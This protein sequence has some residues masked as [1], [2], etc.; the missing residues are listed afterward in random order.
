M[1]V[2]GAGP[3]DELSEAARGLG[4][5]E[6]V[7]SEVRVDRVP[8]D[9]A[10]RI[11]VGGGVGEAGGLIGRAGLVGGPCPRRDG[12]GKV[13]GGLD[14]G[15]LVARVSAGV[16]GVKSDAGVGQRP[17]TLPVRGLGVAPGRKPV[18]I[19]TGVVLA[20]AGLGR[21]CLMLRVSRGGRDSEDPGPQ[22]GAR[23]V[24]PGFLGGAAVE[25]RWGVRLGRMGFR[26]EG[27]VG[28]GLRRR[29]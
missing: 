5:L 20:R 13:S 28:G 19:R 3:A 9:V 6:K 17:E 14:E 25:V 23:E 12:V 2:V 24:A 11:V 1:S 29:S 18:R 10:G 27:R 15:Q 26:E 4:I 8:V 21:G 16:R 7:G 22:L